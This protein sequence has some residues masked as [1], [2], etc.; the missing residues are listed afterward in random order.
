MHLIVSALNSSWNRLDGLCAGT[1]V[2]QLVADVERRHNRHKK[3]ITKKGTNAFV[4][5]CAKSFL[6]E[7]RVLA[8]RAVRRICV[9]LDAVGGVAPKEPAL[10]D[11]TELR[12]KRIKR[13]S[14][15]DMFVAEKK[16]EVQAA[17]MSTKA[18][19]FTSAGRNYVSSSWK[20][21]SKLQQLEYDIDAE[22]ANKKLQDAPQP[23]ASS[24]PSVL[25]LGDREPNQQIVAL[26]PR[27]E[28]AWVSEPSQQIS[29]VRSG[30]M[31]N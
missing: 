1:L 30:A 12:E 20:S 28:F 23:S 15:Y 26:Q 22:D 27:V 8:V 6:E 7:T 9:L 25:A 10:E 29:L 18:L 17:G 14:G 13:K 21:L 4:G 24:A 11:H 16:R 2:K 3:L 19:C 5:F 31:R